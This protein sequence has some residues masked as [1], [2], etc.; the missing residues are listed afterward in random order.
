MTRFSQRYRLTGGSEANSV[1]KWF[2][3]G[4][5]APAIGDFE[6]IQTVTV[7][8]ATSTMTFTSIPATFTHLQIRG[9]LNGTASGTFGNARMGFNSDSGAN[10]SSHN[11]YGYASAT[12][13]QSE[14][15]GNRMY[16]QVY[17]SLASTSSYVGVTVIDILDYANTNK[18][19]TVRSL[20]GIEFNT[21][22]SLR[23]ASGN[24]RNTAAI[25]SIEFV[26]DSGNFNVGSTLALY[27]IKGA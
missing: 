8:T 25:T 10:Y 19:K 11:M 6:S 18:Y 3:G 20:N 15:S 2:G 14:V 17:T 13:A 9:M 5:A 27:G 4:F 16:Y 21:D 22:G 1:N 26:I 12:G 23:F 7:G 24:W